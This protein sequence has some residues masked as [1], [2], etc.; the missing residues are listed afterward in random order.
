MKRRIGVVAALAIG[1]AACYLRGRP[2]AGVDADV[3]SQWNCQVAA[4]LAAA[5]TM[6]GKSEDARVP[7]R[8]WTACDVLASAGAPDSVAL[9]RSGGE[10]SAIWCFWNNAGALVR[11]VLLV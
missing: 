7:R 1:A 4:V 11:Q 10:T 9:N 3:A 8:G 5:D 2:G 6:K